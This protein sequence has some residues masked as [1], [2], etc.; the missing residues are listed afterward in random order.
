[1]KRILAP[2]AGLGLIAILA[3]TG[4][5]GSDDSSS[6]AGPYGGSGGESSKAASAEPAGGGAAVV[7]ATTTPKLGKVVVDSEGF[8]L[9]N[10]H[11]D[12][13]GKP[14]CY[15][16]CEA[17]WPPLTTDGE[18]RAGEGAMAA[19]LGTAER[20][21]GTLQVTY[22][23]WPLYTYTGDSKPGETNGNDV[24]AFGAQWYALQPNGQEP[25]D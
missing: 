19:K 11:K 14:T 10:F 1:M 2:I 25:K 22:A 8:T 13:G 6:S 7:S 18:P 3:M 15:G 4:C 20:K 12:K 17:A 24:D 21:D 5:G 16:A 23:G 9:Y